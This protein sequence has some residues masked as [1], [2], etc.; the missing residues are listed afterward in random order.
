MDLSSA[1]SYPFKS[2][3]KVFTIVL[4]ITI[5]L[6][7]FLAMLLNSYDWTTYFETINTYTYSSGYTRTLSPPGGNFFIS[8]IG[9]FVVLLAQGL[10][11]SGYG[12]RVI[13]HVMEGFEQ[14]P[15]ITFGRNMMDGLSVFLA[16][17]WYG[18]VALPF[19]FGFF[20]LVGMF[21]TPNGEAGL[22]AVMFCGGIILAV[23][24]SFLYMWSFMVGMVRCAAEDK[25]GAMFEIVTNFRLAQQNWKSA[26]S[27]TGYQFLVGIIFGFASQAISMI[28]QFVT[29][30]FAGDGSNTNAL[31]IVFVISMLGTYTI[32][33][34][35]QFSS[36]H[37]MAQF[38]YNV[39][40]MVGYEDE[41]D[42][43]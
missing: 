43:F 42:Q 23:P 26:L 28:L 3:P 16:G 17:I 11:L 39:G 32:Q 35:Q 38:A 21:S 34:I 14:L 12:I 29:T 36:M 1:L 4:V 13:R 41:F 30:P 10:W 5:S 33:I 27:L 9:L 7:V 2:L 19:L 20:M 37:L 25:R 8:L 22:G 24:L 18:I 15:P 6:V 31:L 40:I